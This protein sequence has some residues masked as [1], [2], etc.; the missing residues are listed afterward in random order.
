MT[1]FRFRNKARIQGARFDGCSILITGVRLDETSLFPSPTR[2]AE[3]RSY[4]D[5]PLTPT[6]VVLYSPATR[7][8]P[9]A[10]MGL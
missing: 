5:V 8:M 1:A 10:L 6:E 9:R 7:E 4:P 3:E 2:Y